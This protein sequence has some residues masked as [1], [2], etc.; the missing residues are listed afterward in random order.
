MSSDWQIFNF[1]DD[2]VEIISSSDNDLQDIADGNRL[3]VYF[4]FRDYLDFYKPENVEYIRNGI[5]HTFS[6]IEAALNNELPKPNSYLLRKFLDF[7]LI[8]KNEPQP[9]TH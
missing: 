6:Y 3:I 7:R 2:L 9:C 4:M 5:H 8:Q 1:K